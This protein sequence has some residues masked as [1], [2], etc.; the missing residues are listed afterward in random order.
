MSIAEINTGNKYPLK[1]PNKNIEVLQTLDT[2]RTL[3]DFFFFVNFEHIKQC[4][5]H[6]SSI[7]VSDC[8]QNVFPSLERVEAICPNDCPLAKHLFAKRS[9][10]K[11]LRHIYNCKFV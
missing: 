2:R 6:P 5:A 4:L 11:T 9:G 8:E 10:F 3:F 1:V 7:F